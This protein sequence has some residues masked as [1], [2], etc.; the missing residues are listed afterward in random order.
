MP[1][2]KIND[3]S[4]FEVP[5]LTLRDYSP[6]L[7]AWTSSPRERVE[8]ERLHWWRGSLSSPSHKQRGG[9]EQEHS[10]DDDEW[11]EDGAA[12]AAEEDDDGGS[13]EDEW[14][15]RRKRKPISPV[16]TRGATFILFYHFILLK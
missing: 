10:A 1:K 11:E 13:E 9:G 6:A 12:A 16:R 15:N 3:D 5:H 4:D 2:R 7:V 8:A 14:S